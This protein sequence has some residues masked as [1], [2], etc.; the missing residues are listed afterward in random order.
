MFSKFNDLKFGVKLLIGIGGILILLVINSVAS[1][2]GLWQVAGALTRYQQLTGQASQVTAARADL[3]EAAAEVKQFLID[4]SAESA[5][6]AYTGI[7]AVRK[8]LEIAES[9]AATDAARNRLAGIQMKLAGYEA[10]FE[11]VVASR[12]RRDTAIAEINQLGSELEQKLTSIMADANEAYDAELA[13]KAGQVLRS[14]LIQ[15]AELNRYLLD[16]KAETFSLVEAEQAP[17]ATSF[18][19]LIG[20]LQFGQDDE[21]TEALK[22]SVAAYQAGLLSVRDL[23]VS[24]NVILDEELR[25]AAADILADAAG[26]YGAIRDEQTMIGTEAGDDIRNTEILSIVA[27]VVCVVIGLV[28]TALMARGIS[29]PVR[30]LTQVMGRLAAGESRTDV[31]MTDRGDEMGEMAKAVLVFRESMQKAEEL[32]EASRADQER[33]AKR[34]RR[35]EEL[36]RDFDSTATATLE[37]VSAAAETLRGSANS[38]TET[39]DRSSNMAGMA[40][41]ASNQATENV[42]T[43]ASAAEELS[44]SITE[45]SQQVSRSTQVADQAVQDAEQSRVL[46]DRLA[47]NSA[48]IGEVVKLITDIAEQTNLLALNATI[49]AARAGEAGKGF[50]VVASEVKNLATQTAQATEEISTQIQTIQDDTQHTVSSIQHI[51]DRIEEINRISAGVAT[52]VEE[53]SAATQEIARNVSD[54]AASTGSANE[55]ISGV[56]EATRET[57]AISGEVLSA[58]EQVSAKSGDLSQVVQ[59]FLAEMRTV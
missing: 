18:D 53:Q 26:A 8:D 42:Q 52:A 25:P 47:D 6:N 45:I 56:S 48:K 15:R 16:Q 50:A 7:S 22:S 1:F 58:S 19:D 32:Q 34:T 21:L 23:V 10:A 37:S 28:A 57:T 43:V 9:G 12:A 3:L 36:T 13:F 35:I 51:A 54:A 5:E 40:S 55:N 33:R 14:L 49:E 59:R 46:V 31:P 44:A 41:S 39:A 27:T 24:L 4:G 17:L 20:N 38:L 2:S 11:A 29:G 30:A